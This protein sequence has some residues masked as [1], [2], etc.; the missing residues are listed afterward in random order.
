MAGNSADHLAVWHLNLESVQWPTKNT[1]GSIFFRSSI[2]ALS[3][4]ASASTGS[5]PFTTQ[6]MRHRCLTWP[7]LST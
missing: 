5:F 4:A 7:R 3:L 2:V 6:H 1:F